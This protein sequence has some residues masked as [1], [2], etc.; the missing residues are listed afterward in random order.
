MVTKLMEVM[1]I[2][3]DHNIRT[4]DLK[5]KTDDGVEVIEALLTWEDNNKSDKDFIGS[6]MKFWLMELRRCILIFDGEMFVSC[7]FQNMQS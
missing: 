6:S 3:Q 5:Q 4:D 7:T 1:E 2:L